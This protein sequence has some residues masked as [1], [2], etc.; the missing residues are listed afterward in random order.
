MKSVYCP[1]GYFIMQNGG[2]FNEIAVFHLHVIPKYSKDDFGY[3]NKQYS[4]KVDQ[5]KIKRQFKLEIEND[6]K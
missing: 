1:K 2:S 3:F 5:E 4:N 6:R